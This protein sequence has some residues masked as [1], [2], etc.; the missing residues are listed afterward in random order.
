VE[1]GTMTYFNV[2]FQHLLGK[3]EESHM[4]KP[5]RIVSLWDRFI[6]RTIQYEA[7]LLTTEV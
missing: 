5:I 4:K 2:L 7:R 3:T 1:K 6:L